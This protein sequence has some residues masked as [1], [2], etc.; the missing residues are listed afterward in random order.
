MDEINPSKKED[1]V[2]FNRRKVVFVLDNA[3]IHKTNEVKRVILNNYN[4]LLLP[5]YSPYLNIIE[6]W[7]S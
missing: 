2:R 4:V 6:V 7:F 1:N 3:T 5:P